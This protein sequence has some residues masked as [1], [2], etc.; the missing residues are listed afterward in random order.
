MRSFFD[1]G[2]TLVPRENMRVELA[3]E[4]ITYTLPPEELEKYRALP[5]EKGKAPV[6]LRTRRKK[7]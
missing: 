4:V 1:R 3:G 2:R 5:F 7:A 6:H